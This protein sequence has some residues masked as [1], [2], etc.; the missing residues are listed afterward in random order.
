MYSTAL[1]VNATSPFLGTLRYPCAHFSSTDHLLPPPSDQH[2]TQSSRS[3][4]AWASACPGRWVSY[5][6]THCGHRVTERLRGRW[7]FQVLNCT[8]T[9]MC[10][11]PC[12][13]SQTVAGGGVGS[14]GSMLVSRKACGEEVQCMLWQSSSRS[15][16]TTGAHGS[17]LPTFL[18][19]LIPQDSP[20]SVPSV[21]QR[22][23]T[24]AVGGFWTLH[25]LFGWS[26]SLVPLCSELPI[27]G[28]NA[29][30]NHCPPQQTKE[31]DIWE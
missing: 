24:D 16:A 27:C 15:N 29:L 4:T 30:P 23:A 5:S 2:T 31:L 25:F 14:T 13:S 8:A 3:S 22:A 1:A 17:H 20:C 18:P 9:G 19:K 21:S 12:C 26:Y 11:A 10:A 6:F 28:R 7:W